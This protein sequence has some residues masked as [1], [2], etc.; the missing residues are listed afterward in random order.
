MAI[1]VTTI[2]YLAILVHCI[3][4]LESQGHIL[5]PMVEYT[6]THVIS[7]LLYVLKLGY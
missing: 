6:D 1:P 3:R 7:K 2:K 4:Y 5:F